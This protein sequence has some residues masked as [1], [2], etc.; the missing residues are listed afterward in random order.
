MQDDQDEDAGAQIVQLHPGRSC[1]RVYETTIV[2]NSRRYRQSECKHRGPYL[3]DRKLAAV[4]CQDCG[5]YL[6]PLFALEMLA[7]QEAY[8]NMR[9]RDLA[10]YLAEI[11]QEIKDR[12]RTKCT[13]C[14][15]MTT[16]RFKGEMPKTWMPQP[17]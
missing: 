17:Y 9:Q 8:W 2:D 12:T 16:I 7:Q 11:N 10:K 14:G 5:A 3:I 4:E 6:N 1:E 15:N 13:H